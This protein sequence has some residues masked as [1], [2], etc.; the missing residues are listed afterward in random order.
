MRL[1]PL[2]VSLG[3]LLLSGIEI[4][5]HHLLAAILAFVLSALSA[6]VGVIDNGDVQ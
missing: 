5:D 4:W 2:L 3:L 1:I 6:K